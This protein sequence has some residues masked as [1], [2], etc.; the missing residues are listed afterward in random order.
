[1]LLA[2]AAWVGLAGVGGPRVGRLSE[3]QRNDNATFLPKSAESTE[4][5][6]LVTKISSGNPLPYFVVIERPTA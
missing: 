3:V 5:G 6:A 2:L 4:V 1:V